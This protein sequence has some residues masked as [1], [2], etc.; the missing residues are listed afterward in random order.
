MNEKSGS[1]EPNALA[2]GA[3]FTLGQQDQQVT[4]VPQSTQAHTH[5]NSSLPSASGLQIPPSLSPAEAQELYNLQL[6][7]QYLQDCDIVRLLG[8]SAARC[9]VPPLVG[10]R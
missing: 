10:A 6:Q 3:R 4:Q 2:S 1:Q 5:H 7:H 9:V 8:L